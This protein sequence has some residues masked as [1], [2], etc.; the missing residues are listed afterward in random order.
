MERGA[1]SRVADGGVSWGEPWAVSAESAYDKPGIKCFSFSCH[2]RL[3]KTKIWRTV[4]E[5]VNGSEGRE[6]K[7]REG[8]RIQQKRLALCVLKKRGEAKVR[9]QLS[10]TARGSGASLKPP[11]N[12]SPRR[13]AVGTDSCPLETCCRHQ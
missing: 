11:P 3:Q 6:S 2:Q 10:V 7:R 12:S 1:G 13:Y 5:K 9:S 8:T 4:Q